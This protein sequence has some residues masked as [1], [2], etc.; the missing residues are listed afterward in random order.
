MPH[1]NILKKGL[2][3]STLFLT[4]FLINILFPFV[5]N[6]SNIANAREKDNLFIANTNGKIYTSETPSK[7][8]KNLFPELTSLP[9]PGTLTL[10]VTPKCQG[11]KSVIEMTLKAS[12]RVNFR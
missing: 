10:T 4:A 3:L 11:V 7:K 8:I 1:N 12:T 6:H 9:P 5:I 2:Y